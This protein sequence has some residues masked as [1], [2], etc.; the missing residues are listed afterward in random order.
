MKFVK[1]SP[2]QSLRLYTIEKFNRFLYIGSFLEACSKGYTLNVVTCL[3]A[4]S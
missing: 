1:Q 2:Y 3:L 4:I